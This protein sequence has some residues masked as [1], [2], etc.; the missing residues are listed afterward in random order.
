ML[1][2]EPGSSE[3][4]TGALL[5]IS[6]DT[7]PK[8]LRQSL[9]LGPQ[10][11]DPDSLGG[12]PATPLPPQCGDYRCDHSCA[13]S[14]CVSAGSPSPSPHTSTDFTNSVSPPC[15]S[16]VLPNLQQT[17]RLLNPL[18]E[19]DRGHQPFAHMNVPILS[20]GDTYNCLPSGLA[21]AEQQERAQ[22]SPAVALN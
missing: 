14:S 6:R 7:L 21:E 16:C 2:L 13:A 3:R 10:P 15:R 8:C 11:T 12:Q 20:Q 4:A 18:Q 19:G 17:C 1:G 9:P 5:T 22:L